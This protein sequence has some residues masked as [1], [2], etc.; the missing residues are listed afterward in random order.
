MKT[1][2]DCPCGEQIVGTTEDELVERTNAHLEENHPGHEYT[3]EQILF[4]A[5]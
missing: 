1:T 5:R 4:I 3:R 2:V